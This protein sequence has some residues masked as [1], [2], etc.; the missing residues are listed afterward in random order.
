MERRIGEAV[1]PQVEAAFALLAKKWMGL[2]LYSL[3][4]GELY[5]C[6]LEKAI[7]TLSARV[8][9]ERIREL[10]EAELLRRSVS[11]SS[12]VRVS[13]QLTDKGLS[14]A[15]AVKGIADWAVT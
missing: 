7:P 14:L 3:V 8:L 13:Y 5:F 12:P 2:I 9:T 15:R 11:V 4:G 10:E 1:C 6:E